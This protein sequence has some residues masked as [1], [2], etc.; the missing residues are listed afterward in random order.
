MPVSFL[1]LPRELRDDVYKEL[2]LIEDPVRLF[3]C[4]KPSSPEDEWYTTDDDDEDDEDDEEDEDDH[5]HSVTVWSSDSSDNSDPN[6]LPLFKK[7]TPAKEGSPVL[8]DERDSLVLATSSRV[9]RSSRFR[10]EYYD[11][12]NAL[13]RVNRQVSQEARE[14]LYSHT[15]FVV[16]PDYRLCYDYFPTYPFWGGEALRKADG[17]CV[18]NI[19]FDT[20][21]INAQYTRH[22]W[23]TLSGFLEWE[24][25]G[26]C[27]A[28]HDRCPS[29]QSLK[30]AEGRF[31]DPECALHHYDIIWNPVGRCL[32]DWM[33]M[34]PELLAE[35]FEELAKMLGLDRI[36]LE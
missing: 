25:L 10:K 26:M 31:L 14:Y 18:L 33:H 1:D 19:F 27:L 5:Y 30:I 12:K 23:F 16:S 21:G 3:I 17:A 35:F 13:L 7:E 6:A 9:C 24:L 2:F 22:F 32:V 8:S 36:I 4:E 34:C 15:Q 20:I 11:D 28:L 29:L